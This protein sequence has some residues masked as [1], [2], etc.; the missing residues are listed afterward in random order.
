MKWNNEQ[1]KAIYLNHQGKMWPNLQHILNLQKFLTPIEPLE[2][3]SKE[4]SESTAVEAA[5]CC[6]LSMSQYLEANGI[7]PFGA[8]KLP[9]VSKRLITWN[10]CQ[11]PENAQGERRTEALEIVYTQ[12]S[13]NISS[14]GKKWERC[15]CK[16]PSSWPLPT[17]VK[18]ESDR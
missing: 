13:K 14:Q 6:V 11:V 1:N 17:W 8:P 3:H 10:T 12:V 16:P 7:L 9:G 15:L 4:K 2:F 5:G 18:S